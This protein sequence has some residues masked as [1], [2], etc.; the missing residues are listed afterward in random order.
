MINYNFRTIYAGNAIMTL[1]SKDA[2]KVITVRT[3]AFEKVKFCYEYFSI[4]EVTF[5]CLHYKISNS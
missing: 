2:V 1:K 4:Q 5:V 3:T